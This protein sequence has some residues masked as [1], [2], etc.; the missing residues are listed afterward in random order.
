LAGA[1][2]ETLSR[3]LLENGVKNVL[4][5]Y[6]YVLAFRR[7]EFI[8]R[9]QREYPDVRWFLDSGAFTYAE[10][11]ETDQAR[12][13]PQEEYLRRYFE[14]IDEYGHNYCRITEPDF[15]LAGSLDVEQVDEVREWMLDRWPHLNVMPVWHPGRGPEAWTRYCRDPR[16]KVMA[17]GGGGTVRARSRA[18]TTGSATAR[19]ILSF[20]QMRRMVMEAAHMG[21]P[22]H[23]FAMTKLRLLKVV[24]FAS[25]DSTSWVMGQ[26]YGTLYVFKNNDFRVMPADQKAK[27]KLYR[28]YF[29]AIGCDPDKVIADD[30]SEVRKAN[31]IAWRNLSERLEY[32]Q[33][34]LRRLSMEKAGAP[35]T[36]FDNKGMRARTPKMPGQNRPED[37]VSPE[38]SGEG[39]GSEV[40][41]VLDPPTGRESVSPRITYPKER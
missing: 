40:S 8:A 7:E 9:M 4:Y 24:P 16:I 11:W 26:K 32:M 30:V 1:E 12:L 27:R 29:K 34:R 3:A 20:G 5:S 25:V 15:D 17:I 18:M 28:G 13:P 2:V 31:V 10:K 22:V 41:D 33:R 14:Y 6:F 38:G 21:K 37:V 35:L 19:E 39:S 36:E 23:G